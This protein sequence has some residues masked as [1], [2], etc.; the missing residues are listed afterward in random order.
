M[1]QAQRDNVVPDKLQW[2]GPGLMEVSL[3]PIAT[4]TP[5][6]TKAGFENQHFYT[7]KPKLLLQ[8]VKLALILSVTANLHG[9][10]YLQSSLK[11]VNG[12]SVA[13]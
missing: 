11:T 8:Q 12:L 7:C 6:R 3:T 5:G 2:W 1:T 10:R 4:T 13:V 9:S